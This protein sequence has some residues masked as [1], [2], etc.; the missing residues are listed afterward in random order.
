M[1]ELHRRGQLKLFTEPC[2]GHHWLAPTAH[3]NS[4][5]T[6]GTTTGGTIQGFTLS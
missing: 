3:I 2:C 1:F 4:T 6:A 5:N